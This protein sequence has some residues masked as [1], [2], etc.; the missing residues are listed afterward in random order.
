MPLG[1]DSFYQEESGADLYIDPYGTLP[2]EYSVEGGV[3]PFS[4]SSEEVISDITISQMAVL[5]DGISSAEALGDPDVSQPLDVSVYPTA[6]DSSEEFEEPLVQLGAI[7][8][9]SVDS[10]EVVSEILATSL[11]YVDSVASAESVSDIEITTSPWISPYPFESGSYVER[12]QID[13]TVYVGEISSAES[14]GSVRVDF[15]IYASVDSISGSESINNAT[16]NYHVSCAVSDIETEEGVE[17]P[18]LNQTTH[19]TQ[20]YD[21]AEIS[22]VGVSLRYEIGDTASEEEVSDLYINTVDYADVDSCD[23]ETGYGEP[24]LT[25]TAVIRADSILSR[26]IAASVAVGYNQIIGADSAESSERVSRVYLHN[27]IVDLYID[28]D[29]SVSDIEAFVHVPPAYPLSILSD[30]IVNNSLVYQENTI[31][32]FGMSSDSEMGF[33]GAQNNGLIRAESIDDEELE[34]VTLSFN[35]TAIAT[36]AIAGEEF[37]E[38]DAVVTGT[39]IPD[40][41]LDVV[42]SDSVESV[43]ERY[44]PGAFDGA[45]RTWNGS[46]WEWDLSEAFY[47]QNF[48]RVATYI[49]RWSELVTDP[50][51]KEQEWK[52]FEQEHSYLRDVYPRF[53]KEVWAALVEAHQWKWYEYYQNYYGELDQWLLHGGNYGVTVAQSDSGTVE[54]RRWGDW[55]MSYAV[56]QYEPLDEY[57]ADFPIVD[58][59]LSVVDDKIAELRASSPAGLVVT[60]TPQT[61]Y[62][63]ISAVTAEVS[64]TFTSVSEYVVEDQIANFELYEGVSVSP[65]Y[66]YFFDIPEPSYIQGVPVVPAL[67]TDPACSVD[68][69]SRALHIGVD[70]Y[71][72]RN[73]FGIAPDVYGETV[74]DTDL[75]DDLPPSLYKPLKPPYVSPEDPT[76]NWKPPDVPELPEMPGGWDGWTPEEPPEDD[77]YEEEEDGWEEDPNE[78]VTPTTGVMYR[79]FPLNLYGGGT[80][81]MSGIPKYKNNG[82]K[83]WIF[84]TGK[85][86]K[87][88]DGE[89]C[90]DE[91][92]YDG[93]NYIGMYI[94]NGHL[95]LTDGEFVLRTSAPPRGQRVLLFAGYYGKKSFVGWWASP[96]RFNYRYGE[97]TERANE[98][99]GV[100][101]IMIGRGWGRKSPGESAGNGFTIGSI[102]IVDETESAGSFGS[103][104]DSGGGDTIPPWGLPSPAAEGEARSLSPKPPEEDNDVPTYY[105]VDRTKPHDPVL[106]DLYDTLATAKEQLRQIKDDMREYPNM[107]L[108][109]KAKANQAIERYRTYIYQ[110][111]VAIEERKHDFKEEPQWTYVPTMDSAER[112]QYMKDYER[113]R[114]Q[115]RMIGYFG[116]DDTSRVGTPGVR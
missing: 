25:Q 79:D 49:E 52:P 34:D 68:I 1:P 50:V 40:K 9:D 28:D 44:G 109:V 88:K 69:I 77:P 4:I 54:T 95:V 112:T 91:D 26:E 11:S 114:K 111:E 80:V 81:I 23:E 18:Q 27:P 38:E 32:P 6:I 108:D 29:S 33:P 73:F 22:A 62:G 67:R 85:K 64:D 94:R 43:T 72:K 106:A 84:A 93:P 36:E 74:T 3:E 65:A 92:V 99:K 98:R 87:K 20:M 96:K 12:P 90:V 46:S 102:K 60:N 56:S 110:I 2:S 66:N 37:F 83:K 48:T 58:T 116:I 8:P 19:I 30:A 14:H 63:T 86:R 51:T 55:H 115:P 15:P 13:V 21:G 101:T 105:I 17:E 71:G 100:T 42:Y 10:L 35:V 97:M 75:N 39:F 78:G 45:K 53:K 104:P 59:N 16:L 82:K 57:V 89:L 61:V 113:W 47:A 76:S 5:P 41:A 70:T 7:Y 107:P 103:E 24:T 31:V